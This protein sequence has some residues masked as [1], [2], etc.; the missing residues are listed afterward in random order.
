MSAI[1]KEQR[2]KFIEDAASRYIEIAGL[3]KE[4]ALEFAKAF[5]VDEWIEDGFNGTDAAD[6]EMSNWENDEG[7]T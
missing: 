6:E 4:D 5:D 2:Q 7:Q 3:S 1:T